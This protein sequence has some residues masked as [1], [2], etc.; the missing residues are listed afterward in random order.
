MM[1]LRGVGGPVADGNL[2][3]GART[4]CQQSRWSVRFGKSAAALILL[5]A[6]LVALRRGLP[7]DDERIGLPNVDGDMD[8]AGW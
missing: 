8:E 7:W 5:A 4:A 3:A 1:R 6:V 2:A